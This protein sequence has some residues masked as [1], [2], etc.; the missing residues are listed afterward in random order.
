L[1]IIIIEDEILLAEGL[2]DVIRQLRPSANVLKI[3]PSV[4]M[5]LSFMENNKKDLDLIFS[6]I[7]LEDGLSFEI[8]EQIDFKCPIIFC[9]AFDH[10][11]IRSFETNGIGYILKPYENSD[12]EK[13]LHKY[14]RISES[15][16]QLRNIL[17]KITQENIL[18]K[19]DTSAILINKGSKI[20]PIKHSSIALAWVDNKNVYLLTFDN[21]RLVYNNT[22]EQLAN[23]VGS[24]FFRVSRQYLVNIRSI[25][26]ADHYFSRSLKLELTFKHT[27]DVIVTKRKVSDFLKWWTREKRQ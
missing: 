26:S 10:Y 16:D 23:E 15:S 27:E 3:L 5:A 7:E 1:N 19:E 17:R 14:D 24:G 25:S 22:L 8:F 9:T 18:F 6:D 12:I 11:A 13:F 21:K 4:Q 20:I 2:S